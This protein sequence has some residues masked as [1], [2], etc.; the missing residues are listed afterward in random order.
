VLNEFEQHISNI[1]QVFKQGALLSGGLF[2]GFSGVW[3]DCTTF[4]ERYGGGVL[5]D[6]F[7]MKVIF[8]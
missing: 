2:H 7:Q 6:L 3:L 1:K 4:E 8:L 5:N